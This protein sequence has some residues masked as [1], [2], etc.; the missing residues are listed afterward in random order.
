MK[1]AKQVSLV[2]TNVSLDGAI[3]VA[4]LQSM[5]KRHRNPAVPLLCLLQET[6]RR[7]ELQAFAIGATAVLDVN[8]P[9]EIL[10]ATALDL[11]GTSGAKEN[12]EQFS[13]K[14]RAAHAGAVVALMMDDAANDNLVS[15]ATLSLG[16]DLILQ[17]VEEGDIRTWLDVVWN[18]DDATYRHSLLVAGLAAAFALKLGF[19]LSDRRRLTKAG[20]LHDIGKAKLPLHLLSKSSHLTVDEI[21][22]LRT[23][24]ALGYDTLVRQGGF[25]PE[26]LSVVRHH[27]EYLDGSGYPDGLAGD[28]VPDLVRL[29]TICDVYAELIEKSPNTDPLMS[30]RAINI[31]A[32]MAEKLDIG[33]FN[34]FRSTVCSPLARTTGFPNKID[35]V[36]SMTRLTDPR[37]D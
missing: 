13:A 6:S 18:Y 24:A 5:L 27:H 37:S 11:I 23:H 29:V 14:T 26:Q 17:A 25:S 35:T 15:Q 30:D 31:M 2:V 28:Q 22:I 7:T 16:A 8:A 1:L 33:L 4:M 10:I 32:Q 34:I 12:P 9:R 20:L 19:R 3:A 36:T 21:A